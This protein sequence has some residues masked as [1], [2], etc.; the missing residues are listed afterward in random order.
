MPLAQPLPAL[1]EQ[2]RELLVE[3]LAATLAA[4]KEWLP[5]HAPKC[6]EVDALRARLNDANKERYRNTISSEEYQRRIDTIRAECYDLIDGLEEADFEGPSRPTTST[7]SSNRQGSVLYRVPHRMPVRKP[8]ICT[9]RVAINEEAFLDD[10]VLDD[11]VRLRPRIE[12]SD[13]MKA[14]LLD[15]EGEV[16]A[17]RPLSEAEQ[18]VRAE[19]YTQWLFSVTPRMEGEHQL[20]VKVSMMEYVPNLGRYVPRE[21]SVLE[22]VTIFTENAEQAT[23]E[24]PLKSTGEQLALGPKNVVVERHIQGEARRAVALFLAFLMAGSSATWAF[25]PPPLRDWWVA[26]IQ[27]T[28]V[29]Y[30]RYIATYGQ[31]TDPKVRRRVETA[32]LKSIEQAPEVAKIEAFVEQFPETEHL[33][34]VKQTVDAHPELRPA[35][36]PILESAS[37]RSIETSPSAQKISDFLREYPQSERLPELARAAAAQSAVLAQVQP[38]ISQAIVEKIA[39]ADSPAEVQTLLLA[40]EAVGDTGAVD[41]VLRIANQKQWD[42]Q[43][44]TQI[45]QI[46]AKVREREAK[47]ATPL[48]APDNTASSSQSLHSNPDPNNSYRNLRSGLDMVLVKGGTFTMGDD[49]D[50]DSDNPEHQVTVSD[51]QIGKYEVTQGDWKKVMGEYPPELEFPGCDECPVENVM[52]WDIQEFLQKL[53]RQSGRKYRLPTEAEWE[54][55]ARGGVQSKSYTFA[56]GNNLDKVAWY[57]GN[58]RQKTHIVGGKVPNELGIYDMSGNVWECCSDLYDYDYY[59]QSPRKDP[60]GPVSGDDDPV[61][62]GGS[63]RSSPEYCRL[64]V[65][66]RRGDHHWYDVLGFRLARDY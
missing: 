22:T 41:Q 19:G 24:A 29:A 47:K 18:L 2:L 21:I 13:M 56:G 34:E 57:D 16:F 32:Y 15:P 65:R 11:N 35:A 5:A 64:V 30:D 66:G 58:S 54:F 52:E 31:N 26:S 60:K 40:L 50:A 25:T 59:R 17:I 53:N 37:I 10:I 45:Q 27:D 43:T 51:F 39:A 38:A 28:A 8:T 48:S 7:Q 9:V 33:T 1:R 44:L 20:L 61:Y 4:L 55:A 14:E 6:A 42:R 3:D 46:A 23:E 36:L 12:V 49:Q 63:F 62:R